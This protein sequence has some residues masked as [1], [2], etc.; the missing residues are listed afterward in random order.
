MTEA[1]PSGAGTE[2][3]SEAIVLTSYADAREGFRNRDLR[4]ALYDE[5]HL[6]MSGVIVN[7]HGDD[8]RARRRLENRLFRRDTFLYYQREVIP[9]VVEEVL[10][11]AVADGHGDLLPMARRTMMTL[12]AAIA[13]VDRPAGTQEEFDRLYGLMTRL[14]R[15]STLVHATGDKQEI[16]ADGQA[17]LREF[18]EEFLQPS[19]A[20]RTALLEQFHSGA[21]AEGEL[22]R[23]VLTT[24]LR[25][26]DNLVLTPDIVLR[27]AAYF[28]WVGSF[29]TSD[30]FV[31]AMNHVF[32]WLD[33][34]PADRP[35]LR[36]DGLVL[37]RFVHESLR[38]HPASPESRR[39]AVADVRLGSGLAIGAGTAVTIDLVAAN[40]DP[41]V[42]GQDGGAFDPYR[43]LAA[44]VSPWG[45]TFG[46]GFHACLGQE[47]AGGLHSDAPGDPDDHLSGAIVTMAKILLERGARPDQNDPPARDPQST[48]PHFGRYPVVFDRSLV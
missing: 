25:N 1:S 32:E 3:A 23:D 13:G 38:L 24:L 6:L 2:P 43:V 35:L 31:H 21:L 44:D 5:G 10:A 14:S 45:L 28:P 18:D 11:P 4:Q 26:Q 15:G 8:H 7:L 9:R 29:S 47:L 22:P 42:F 37:Q 16:E 19:I 40:R 20:R 27:E 12:S 17:A 39:I 48:R 30:A 41:T 36:A 33:E 34:R 46:S